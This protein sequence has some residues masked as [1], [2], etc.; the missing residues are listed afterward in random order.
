M[1]SSGLW[2]I[3]SV[4]NGYDCK[5]KWEE[6]FGKKEEVKEEKPKK[7][8]KKRATRK[9]TTGTKKTPGKSS[10]TKKKTS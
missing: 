4:F 6:M 8:T 10:K 1:E 7:A 2:R 9:K 5:G 3:R